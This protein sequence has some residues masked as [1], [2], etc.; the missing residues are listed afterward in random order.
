[1]TNKHQWNVNPAI[2][3]FLLFF[4]CTISTTMYEYVRTGRERITDTHLFTIIQLYI[5]LSL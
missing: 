2:R 4:V 5:I 3:S 1:M